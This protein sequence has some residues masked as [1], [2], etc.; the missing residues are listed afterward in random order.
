[1]KTGGNRTKH[2]EFEKLV[3][4]HQKAIYGLCLNILGTEEDANEATQEAF[5]K[6]FNGFESFRAQATFKT[7]L[8]RIAI[9]CSKTI[10]RTRRK[11]LER[12]LNTDISDIQ[13]GV[14][15]KTGQKI[16]EQEERKQMLAALDQ[17][18]EKQKLVLS[19]RIFEDLPFKEIA[20]LLKTREGSAKTNYHYAVKALKT[21]IGE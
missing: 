16:Q 17:L 9:N 12:H 21:K 20:K 4:Q 5:V 14:E 18:P 1:V 7:W 8:Y 13:I 10:L 19:L 3:R 6:A 11:K 15:P 2:E